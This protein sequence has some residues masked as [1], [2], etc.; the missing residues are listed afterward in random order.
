V[1]LLINFNVPHLRDGIKRLVNG[2]EGRG[3]KGIVPVS[4]ASTVVERVK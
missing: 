3:D 2:R 4:P 1:G